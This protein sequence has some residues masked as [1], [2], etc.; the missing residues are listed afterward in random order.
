MLR[1]FILAASLL[2]VSSGALA[3]GDYDHGY[4][5][6]VSV[7]PHFV[8]SFGGGRHHDGFRVLYEVGGTRYW[9]HSHYHPSHS[10]YAPPPRVYYSGAYGHE[11]RDWGHHDGYRHGGYHHGDRQGY[12]HHNRHHDRHSDRREHHRGHRGYD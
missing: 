12:R 8:L 7:E 2:V 9:T 11:R 5:R 1:T 6:V 10:H 4:G 3:R